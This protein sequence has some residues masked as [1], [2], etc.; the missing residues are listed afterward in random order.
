M[1][2][3]LAVLFFLA[4]MGCTQADEVR[5]IETKQVANQQKLYVES[6][7]PPYF[8][9]SLERFLMTELY[10][11]RNE[12]V[13]TW[14]YVQSPFTGKILWTCPSVGYPIPGGTQLTNPEQTIGGGGS[15]PQA[16]PNGLFS[17]SS[18]Q[19]TYVM[20]VNS[21]GTVS[22]AYVE[23]TVRTFS[24]P[25]YE[26]DGLLAP[27]DKAATIRIDVSQFMTPPKP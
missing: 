26:R 20:C 16:E 2:K 18:S 23:D 10:R 13:A 11:R 6:Q 4:M 5:R 14:S 22:P 19:G 17:P 3:L 21:D 9:R 7:P 27:T 25:M 15:I 1:K 12:A 24:Q 8:E